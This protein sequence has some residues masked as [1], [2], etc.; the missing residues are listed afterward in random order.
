[1]TTHISHGHR[2]RGENHFQILAGWFP[3]VMVVVLGNV[4]PALSAEREAPSLLIGYTEGRNDQQ[5]GQ[6]AN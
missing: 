5:G 1:M 6:F 2:A 3:L 4:A